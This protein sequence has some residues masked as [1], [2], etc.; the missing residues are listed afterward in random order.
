MGRFGFFIM[1]GLA[2]LAAEVPVI[3]WPLKWVETFF[4]EISHGLAAI[5]TGGGIVSI[6]LDYNGSGLCLSA[7]GWSV[8]VAFAGYLGASLWGFAIFR[9]AGAGSP[10][11]GRGLGIALAAMVAVS[12]LLWGRGVSTLIVS[13]VIVALFAF[14]ALADRAGL[15]RHVLAFV[16]VAV[17]VSAV[18]APLVLLV[19]G[20]QSDAL[21]LSD[22]TLVPRI[23]W[24]VVWAGLAIIVLYRM[25][26]ASARLPAFRRS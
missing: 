16:G 15:A 8:A 5:V 2:L 7:G 11:S 14:A 3:G 22:I 26:R 21:T 10:K 24:V 18:R 19:F 17:A 9:V 23:V 25:W 1:V 20:G 12:W 13:A 6:V 4:H